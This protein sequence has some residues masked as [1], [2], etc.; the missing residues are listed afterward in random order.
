MK[1]NYIKT[2]ESFRNR[3]LNE[4]IYDDPIKKKAEERYKNQKTVSIVGIGKPY[5]RINIIPEGKYNIVEGDQEGRYF[6]PRFN[7]TLSKP[8]SPFD[9]AVQLAQETGWISPWNYIEMKM[10][11]SDPGHFGDISRVLTFPLQPTLFDKPVNEELLGGLIDFFKNMWGKAVKDLK[12]LG[13]KPTTDQIDNWIETKIFNPSDSNYL[14]KS[15]IEEFGKKPEA[16][17]EDCLTLVDNILDPETGALG[18]Q[19][20]QPLYENLTKV[21][22]DNLAPLE[23]IKYYFEVARNRA[24]KQFKYAG[25]PDLK[26]GEAKIDPAA[27]KMDI[28]DTT[29][30]PDLKKVLESAG[31]DNKKK[32]D[33]ALGWVNKTLTPTLLKYIK[34]VD[35]QKVDEYLKSKG[36]EASAGAGEL[37][38]GDTVVYKRDKFSEDEWKKVS[39]DDKKKTDE[40]PMQDLQD[41]EMIGVKKVKEVSGDDVSFEDADFK[42]T[43][44]DILMKVEVDQ[45]EEAKKAAESL[46]KIKDDADKM[47]TVA[48]LADMLQ[49]DA[50]KDQ[51]EEIKN[52]I[53]GEGEG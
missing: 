31:E 35:D 50:K 38:P 11:H 13:D 47:K 26:I 22:G 4:S 1:K 43:K 6:T 40:G 46:G 29:H 12:K 19:G 32:K 41:K 20:L 53:S 36:I 17:N 15:I 28:T 42:K 30:L 33:D 39:D 27:K 25:G 52:I 16:N 37:K 5:E 24:I 45:S 9:L 7:V 48:D 23:T 18:T 3:S 14:F 21:F 34:E 10:G 2:F 49:D 51:V 8:M 44:K